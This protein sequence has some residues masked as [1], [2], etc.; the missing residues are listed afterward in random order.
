MAERPRLHSP[1]QRRTHSLVDAATIG[2]I[3]VASGYRS[4]PLLTQ[5]HPALEARVVIEQAKGMLA[6]MESVS[7]GE[8][9]TAPR[10][11]ARRRDLRLTELAYAF[12]ER[13]TPD[14]AI[15]GTTG[16]AR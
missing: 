3:Q 12:I 6:E 5:L 8:A 1:Q 13:S 2:L 7:P 14:L 9:P 15:A 10:E 16:H 11:Q 4:E